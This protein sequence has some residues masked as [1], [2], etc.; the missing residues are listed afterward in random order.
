M[1]LLVNEGLLE[2]VRLAPPALWRE[3][4]G[5]VYGDTGA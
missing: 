4:I 2:A 1:R 5:Q 3:A